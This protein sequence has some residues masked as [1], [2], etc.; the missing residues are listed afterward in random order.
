MFADVIAIV[1][2]Y[3]VSITLSHLFP[4]NGIQGREWYQGFTKRWG[5]KLSVRVA[6]N[7][8]SLRASSCTADKITS[9]FNTP[10][11]QFHEANI[12]NNTW[13]NL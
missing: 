12:N 3:L 1:G 11:K 13:C 9:Y 2:G 7:I 4:S 8:S 10:Q 5:H 6:G